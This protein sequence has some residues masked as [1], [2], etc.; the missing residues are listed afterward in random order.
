MFGIRY[1]K[2]PPTMHVLQFKNGKPVRDG[3]GLS[4]FYYQPTSSIMQVPVGSN[5]APFLFEEVTADFQDVTIQGEITYRISDPKLIVSMLDFSIDHRG[6]YA[7]DDPAKLNERLVR[8]CQ[9]LSRSYTQRHKLSAVLGAT[10]EL[11]GLIREGLAGSEVV[12]M[13]GIE[14]LSVSLVSIKPSPEMSKA[15]EAEAREQLL[16]DAD[17]AVFERRNAAVESERQIKENELNTEIAVQEKKRQVRETQMRADITVEQQRAELVDQ[18][19]ENQRK[20]SEARGEAL[21]ATLEPLKDVDWR[22]LVAASSGGMGSNEL[23]A[24]AF[25]DLAD[26]AEKIGT[27]NI[28]PDLLQ[29]LMDGGPAPGGMPV[30]AGT[31]AHEQPRRGRKGGR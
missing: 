18:R 6:R 17:R 11:A 26:N 3:V 28:S 21:K 29:A 5:D 12:Q 20:E 15:L 27:L 2:A 7:S 30:S 10:D 13:L 19:V 9:M 22:T 24:M 14:V 25:R 8:A 31:Q 4:F 23:I 16:Q 1:L